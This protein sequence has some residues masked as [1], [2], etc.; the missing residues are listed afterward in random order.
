VRTNL[1]VDSVIQVQVN[2]E[3][4]SAKVRR[5]GTLQYSTT[6]PYRWAVLTLDIGGECAYAVAREDELASEAVKLS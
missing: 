4:R 5:V 6:S 3:L 1:A 2:N